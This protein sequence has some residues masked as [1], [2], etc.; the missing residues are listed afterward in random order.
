MSKYSNTQD[1]N[2]FFGFAP[3]CQIC[4]HT[5]DDLE[6]V[7]TH[8][9]VCPQCFWKL[10]DEMR[11]DLE[12]CI[13]YDDEAVV[14]ETFITRLADQTVRVEFEAV[15]NR[16]PGVSHVQPYASIVALFI[17]AS[18]RVIKTDSYL[19]SEI[20]QRLNVSSLLDIAPAAWHDPSVNT[21]TMFI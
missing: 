12:A 15:V 6:A 18:T 13:E 9:G 1:P 5:S 17:T 19:L 20:R 8:D 14:K 10:E 16:F 21:E 11:A 3:V 7:Y 4:G 2:S